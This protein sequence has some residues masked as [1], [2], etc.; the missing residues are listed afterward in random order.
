MNPALDDLQETVK[1][2]PSKDEEFVDVV[3]CFIYDLMEEDK[4][5]DMRDVDAIIAIHDQL[6]DESMKLQ[7]IKI[8]TDYVNTCNKSTFKLLDS[9]ND[10]Y[11]CK[12]NPVDYW[13][14]KCNWSI[15][16]E[17]KERTLVEYACDYIKYLIT[18][19]YI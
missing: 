3:S 17:D 13:N 18:Q 6:C 7:N 14:E 1:Y 9:N 10:T 2:Y 19:K 8:V 16:F 11:F 5:R 15:E 12:V 4:Y